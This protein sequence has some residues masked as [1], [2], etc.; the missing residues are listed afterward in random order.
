MLSIRRRSHQKY[1]VVGLALLLAGLSF[2][3]EPRRGVEGEAPRALLAEGA[4][5][6]PIKEPAIK[7][8][9]VDNFERY[10]VGQFPTWFKTW[11]FQRSDTQKVYSVRQEEGNKFLRADDAKDLSKQIFKEFSWDLKQYPYF[12]WRWRAKVLPKNAAENVGAKN[13]SACGIYIVF[14]RMS[15]RALKYNWSTTL[16]VGTTFEKKP[17]KMHMT[18]VDSGSQHLGKWRSHSIHIPTEYKNLFKAGMEKGPSG[19]A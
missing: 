8:K 4:T 2:A 15:G 3:K 6:A 9:T 12:K 18:M 13:D 14:G 1:V 17:G 11:P 7:T 16:P 5:Q 10:K 19:F